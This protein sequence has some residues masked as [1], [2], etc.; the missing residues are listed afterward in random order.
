MTAAEMYIE[1]VVAAIPLGMPLRQQ[2]AMELRAT[3]AERLE[4]G[5]SLDQILLQLGD[6]VVL[7]ESYLAA[8]P[9][10]NATF[11]PRVAARC[12]DWVM[13]WAIAGV[14]VLFFGTIIMAGRFATQNPGSD[15]W[16]SPAFIMIC[17]AG[18]ITLVCLS[19]L[20]FVMAE[21]A[22]GQTVGKRLLSL[23]VVRESGGRIS[24]G[25][26]VVRQLPALLQM[27]LIDVMFVLFTE[28]SQRAFEM[29]SKTRCVRA[30][31]SGLTV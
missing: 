1:R 20:Y 3:I 5:Q 11:W 6:P 13:L 30:D 14:V 31:S 28:K 4:R 2:V 27:W 19:P 7:A 22:Y 18:L 17:I 21:Y 16:E 23:R 26:S 9:L 12:V 24:F 8:V 25:Q 10:V 15:F 29:L